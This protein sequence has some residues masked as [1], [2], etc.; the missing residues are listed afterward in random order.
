MNRM[1]PELRS[2]KWFLHNNIEV[3]ALHQSALRSA[4]FDMDAYTGQPVI[5]IANTWSELNSCNM[6]LNVI[7]AHVKDGIREAGGIPVEFPTFSLGED[8]MKPTAMLYRNL[9]SMVVEEN[10]RTYPLDGVILLGNCDKTVP[11]LAMGAI[12]ANLPFIQLNAGPKKVGTFK[13]QRM[14]SGTDL[15]KYS[16]EL[17]LG[18]IS[19]DD[20]DAIVK[21]LSC[22]FGACNTMGSASTMNGVLEALG[23]MPLGLST[24]P[25]A[26]EERYAL[27]K[28]AGR[29]IVSM[30]IEKLTPQT[31]LT[32]AAFENAIKVCMALGGST[33][34]VLHL[35]AMAGRLNISVYP[36]SFE[37]AGQ[38]IPCIANVQPGGEF[39]I[40]D[41]DAA[42]GIPAVM[43]EIKE[44]LHLSSITYTGSPLEK[45]L[46]HKKPVNR[47]VI[48]S[49][50]NPVKAAPSLC[51][52]HGSLAP[53]GAI[54][55]TSAASPELFVHTGPAIVFDDYK[56]MLAVVEDPS[57]EF[58]PN[59]VLILRNV[60]PVG[61]PGMPEWGMIPIPISLQKKGI[62]DMVRISDA[63]MSGTSF[64]T[65][66]LHVAPEA[67][68]GGPLCI[69]R[70]N[71]LISL[72]IPN[73]KLDICISQEEI[74]QRRALLKPVPSKYTRGYLKLFQT[75]VLQANEGCDFEMLKPKTQKDLEFIEPIIGRS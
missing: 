52:L 23:V 47:T 50:S 60:G 36:K 48:K 40:D 12:S 64:G 19:L 27:S 38:K 30:V 37:E 13:G 6:S 75:N 17:K 46:S 18:K 22:G 66:I 57:R 32:K 15:W 68:V 7:A 42:G 71:D 49:C 2:H 29:R 14:G 20:W 69:V 61:L 21:S 1:N 24:M 73:R 25:V 59:A 39:L 4:G 34:A 5:G 3:R 44:H 55:K 45:L 11:G 51:V 53:D 58:D 31:I 67:S 54:I 33:N 16:D 8:L 43:Q 41:L 35:T 65:V 63:R 26:C 28:E 9:L 72:D 74:Q 70:N 10:L 56:E 62:R